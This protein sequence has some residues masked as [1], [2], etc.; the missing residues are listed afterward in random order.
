MVLLSPELVQNFYVP[1]VLQTLQNALQPPH[2]VVKLFCGVS[3]TE[4]YEQFFEDWSQ[5]KQLTYDDDSE[6]YV[7]TVLKAISEGGK[8]LGHLQNFLL[9]VGVALLP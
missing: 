8:A 3:E 6:V 1:A 2:K 5:W 7:T 9:V 4:T